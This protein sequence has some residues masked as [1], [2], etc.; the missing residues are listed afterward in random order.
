M[1]SGYSQWIFA[2][3]CQFALVPYRR[4]GC[5]CTWTGTTTIRGFPQC[6]WHYI[7]QQ[8][9]PSVIGLGNFHSR[10]P[11]VMQMSQVLPHSV[12]KLSSTLSLCYTQVP[13]FWLSRRS[14]RSDGF[15]GKKITKHWSALIQ[16]CRFAS[17]LLVF[18]VAVVFSLFLLILSLCSSTGYAGQ[19]LRVL[20]YHCLTFTTKK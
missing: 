20:I 19:Q 15:S 8:S 13:S 7:A 11:K 12:H 17:L 9:L 5:S 14:G 6:P 10:K 3:S 16:V 1:V 18:V 4:E 2:G